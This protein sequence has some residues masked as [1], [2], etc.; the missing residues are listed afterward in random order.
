[1]NIYELIAWLMR[2][3]EDSPRGSATEVLM[4]NEGDM[5]IEGASLGRAQL[6]HGRSRRSAVVILQVGTAHRSP[7]RGMRGRPEDRTDRDLHAGMVRSGRCRAITR[8]LD[9][10][11]AASAER[12]RPLEDLLR[13][14][15]ADGTGRAS[16]NEGQLRLFDDH[17]EGDFARALAICEGT[18]ALVIHSGSGVVYNP[19]EDKIT[20]PIGKRF[21]DPAA[22]FN[23]RFRM[24]ALWAERRV[25]W[26]GT[27]AEGTL[28]S[29]LAAYLLAEVAGI[30]VR[31]IGSYRDRYEEWFHQIRSDA[32]FLDRMLDQAHK[33]ANFILAKGETRQ[34]R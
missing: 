5:A 16:A 15:E 13:V 24:T 17:P 11:D 33:V 27:R 14:V 2:L 28:I 19:Q 18:G 32:A 22:Y 34:S 8:W 6:P 7:M 4:R 20:I 23:A 29:M 3:S 21:H 26:E 30:S 12:S 1:M 10:L 9:E 25:G 31:D